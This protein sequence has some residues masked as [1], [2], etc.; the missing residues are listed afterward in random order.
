MNPSRFVMLWL[1]LVGPFWQVGCRPRAKLGAPQ[2]YWTPPTMNA[3]GTPLKDLASYR[4]YRG[5]APGI[6]TKTFDTKDPF[7]TSEYLTQGTWYFA[8][9]AID[10]SGNESRKSEELRVNIP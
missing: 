6:Y 4:L 9:T 8:V 2:F 5:V 7:F 10:T 1:L 3:D